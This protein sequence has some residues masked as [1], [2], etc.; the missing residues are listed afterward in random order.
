MGY[1]TGEC[2]KI[3]LHDESDMVYFKTATTI[4]R[5]IVL[6][7][8]QASLH[9]EMPGIQTTN[10]SLFDYSCMFLQKPRLDFSSSAN[11]GSI[12]V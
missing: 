2:N 5:D 3:F 10:S 11:A 7:H 4:T 12:Q 1:I 9:F 6:F 8:S